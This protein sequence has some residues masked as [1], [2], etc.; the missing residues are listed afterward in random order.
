MKDFWKKLA[1]TVSG[2]PIVE[3]KSWIKDEGHRDIDREIA[4]SVM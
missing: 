2:C 3:D 1:A 4:A